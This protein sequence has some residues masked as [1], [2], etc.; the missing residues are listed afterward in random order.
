MCKY[1]P[2]HCTLCGIFM[3]DYQIYGQECAHKGDPRRCQPRMVDDWAMKGKC[4]G[5]ICENS[6]EGEM[7]DGEYGFEREQERQQQGQQQEEGQQQQEQ[8]Q[9]EQQQQEQQQQEQQQQ[10][11]QQEQEQDRPAEE[12]GEG[13]GSKE[14]VKDENKGDGEGDLDMGTGG[15]TGAGQG[16]E[17]DV[18]M[19]QTTFDINMGGVEE[20][21]TFG[22]EG[23]AS[24]NEEASTN[25]NKNED[26]AGE[27]S[28][29]E[30]ES[31]MDVDIDGT[32]CELVIRGDTDI[33]GVQETQTDREGLEDQGNQGEE[34][35]PNETGIGNSI[36]E[37]TDV[38][39][40]AMDTS[41]DFMAE[42]TIP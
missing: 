33:E 18:E 7:D 6:F 19:E 12:A 32:A 22:D 38:T 29:A 41:M 34:S 26:G 42:N 27:L 40:V 2:I 35:S 37:I 28:G 20:L 13:D 16:T 8:Q 17:R 25:E 21:Q 4:G 5:D 9:Q 11:E 14:D 24:F 30:M 39:G 15:G 10:E 31:S 3:N 1:Q 36:G 23:T